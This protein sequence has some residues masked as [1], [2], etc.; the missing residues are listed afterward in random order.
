MFSCF[1]TT[2]I[3]NKI[4][5][6]SIFW[7]NKC[8]LAH[9]GTLQSHFCW[10]SVLSFLKNGE[11]CKTAVIYNR[12]VASVVIYC[13]DVRLKL[14]VTAV[15]RPS[16]DGRLLVNQSL[17]CGSMPIENPIVFFLNKV[18][19]TLWWVSAFNL[20]IGEQ[21]GFILKQKMFEFILKV[22]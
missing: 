6:S 13:F 4:G 19:L 17:V 3:E 16:Y 7:L 22:S 5:T 10:N 8:S 1:H 11:H 14:A 12:G 15:F 9:L 18:T 21:G 20:P 2:R